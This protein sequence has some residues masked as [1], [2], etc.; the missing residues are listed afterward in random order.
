MCFLLFFCRDPVLLQQL[1][2]RQQALKL[3]ANSMYGC[4][5]FSNSRFFARPLAELITS[6]GRDI[7]Q[8]TV[9]LVQ[10][11]GVPGLEVSSMVLSLV[12]SQHGVVWACVVEGVPES[13]APIYACQHLTAHRIKLCRSHHWALL[14]CR[15]STVT[16]T[17]S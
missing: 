11:L 17:Q 2:V 6:Q 7:L 16:Q 3:T 10:D 1:T 5:G 9:D 8:S 15:S 13:M 12:S 14:P 4:L